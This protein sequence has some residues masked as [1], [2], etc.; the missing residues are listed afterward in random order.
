MQK[1]RVSRA[2][3]RIRDVDYDLRTFFNDCTEAFPELRLYMGDAADSTSGG[4]PPD[5]EYQRTIGALFAFYWI[6]RVDIDGKAGFC[7]GVDPW[8]DSW[9][10]SP[11]GQPPAAS[12]K[13][14]AEM[15]K[16]EKRAHFYAT[17]PWQS[18]TDLLIDA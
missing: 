3:K 6:M 18:F 4:R 15:T 11:V 2:A 8:S 9:V 17:G 1:G 14:F 12:P 5:D 7:F 10:V 16:N 13:A